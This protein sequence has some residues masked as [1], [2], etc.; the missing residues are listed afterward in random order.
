[1]YDLSVPLW[2]LF[3]QFGLIAS[4]NYWGDAT[5]IVALREKARSFL[6]TVQNLEIDFIEIKQKL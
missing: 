2:E 3:S 4:A 1:M 6:E 5:K